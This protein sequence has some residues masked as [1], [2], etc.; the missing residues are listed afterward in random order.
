MPKYE[1]MDLLILKKYMETSPEVITMKALGSIES[2][3]INYLNFTYDCPELN[4]SAGMPVLDT[5]IWVG[6]E[7]RETGIPRDM[8]EN[9][10]GAITTKP[11]TLKNVILHEF[12]KKPMS[13]KTPNLASNGAP[14]SQKISTTT[15]E[16]IRRL[17]TP[18]GTS[19]QRKLRR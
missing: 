19:P 5:T 13:D 12:Y 6:Q 17:K 14:E 11:G 18:P 3:V 2:G 16:I 7:A 9:L 4:S 8:L 10:E 1:G 15:Q